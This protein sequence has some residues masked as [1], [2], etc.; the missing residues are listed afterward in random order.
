MFDGEHNQIASI[1]TGLMLLESCAEDFRIMKLQLAT[2][3]IPGKISLTAPEQ[4]YLTRLYV[5]SY[6]CL[7]IQWNYQLHLGECP[8]QHEL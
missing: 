3:S 8:D 5:K 1:Y 6:Y 7:C 2:G 4:N